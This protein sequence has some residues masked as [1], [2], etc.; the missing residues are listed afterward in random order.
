[1]KSLFNLNQAKT[2]RTAIFTVLTVGGMTLTGPAF[3][4]GKVTYNA[5]DGTVQIPVVHAG[6]DQYNVTMQYEPTEDGL[7]KFVVTEASLLSQLTFKDSA[8]SDFG[9]TLTLIE[10]LAEFQSQDIEVSDPIEKRNKTFRAIPINAVLTKIYGDDWQTR[11]EVLVSALDGFKSSIAVEQ[12]LS[13]NG[14]LAFEQVNRPQFVLVKASDGKYVELGPFW[15]IWDNLTNAEL[16][17]SDSYFWPYQ[18][19][20][21]DLVTFAERFTNAVP[22]EGSSESV[23]QGFVAARKYCMHCHKVNGDGGNKSADLIQAELIA[24]KTD[25]RLKEVI[26]DREALPNISG[27]VLREE[28]ANREQVADDIIAYLRTMEAAQ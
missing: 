3:S 7:L 9:N 28:V 23:Q 16:Q 5:A 21:F 25:E 15:L 6:S 11:E 17:A 24:T 18:V 20:S 27:M 4:D 10:M 1:M 2:L 26:L 13:Y 14:Y 8:N 19:A 22:P 12:F